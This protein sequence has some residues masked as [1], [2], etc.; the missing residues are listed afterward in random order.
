MIKKFS[1]YVQFIFLNNL[2]EHNPDA[3]IYMNPTL[4]IWVNAK[5]II[6]FQ[7]HTLHNSI[8]FFVGAPFKYLSLHIASTW[9][10]YSQI[11]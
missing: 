11:K 5:F 4:I 9:S 7:N 6:K 2:L 10:H 3:L 1:S 8:F